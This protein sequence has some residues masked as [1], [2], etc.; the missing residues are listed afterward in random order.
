MFTAIII[1]AITVCIIDKD[2]IKASVF[3]LIGA[4]LSFI[5]LMHAP[6]LTW[7]AAPD[8]MVGYLLI[9][10]FFVLLGTTE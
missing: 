7:N 1:G 4:G 9:S 6:S 8:F 5:G 3:S 10:L 2:F